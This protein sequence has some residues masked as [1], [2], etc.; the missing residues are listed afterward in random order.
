MILQASQFTAAGGEHI[1]SEPRQPATLHHY[2][3]K[4]PLINYNNPEITIVGHPFT[5]VVTEGDCSTTDGDGRSLLVFLFHYFP[6]GFS[7]N[8][9]P[10][11]VLIS[12]A[13]LLLGLLVKSPTSTILGMAAN[14]RRCSC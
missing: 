14:Q 4:Y 11:R 9:T 10:C 12:A 6:C 8:M 1:W 2:T 7:P 3:K 5:P 13:H